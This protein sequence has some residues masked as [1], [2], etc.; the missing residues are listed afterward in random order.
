MFGNVLIILLLIIAN[1]VFSMSEIAVISSRKVRLQ[2]TA[3]DGDESSRVALDLAEKPNQFLSTIQ[4]GITLI[5]TLSGAL[6]SAVFSEPLAA[7]IAQVEVLKPYAGSLSVAIVVLSITYLSLVVGELVPKQLALADPERIA[8]AVARP[9]QFLSKLTYPIVRILSLST[10][11]VIRMMRL[12]ETNE[13]PVTE[14]EIRVLMEQGTEVGVF[15]KA[16]THM[17]E[18]VFRLGG[19][20]VGAVMTP[21]TDIEWLDLDDDLEISMAKV[22]ASPHQHFPLAEGSLDNVH[23]I[24]RAKDFLF[25]VQENNLDLLKM[26][27][28]ALFVPESTSALKLLELL[29]SAS[30]NLALVMD[31]YGGVL[32][33][34]TLF[35][36]MEAIVGVISIE[37]RP[38]QPLAT[39]RE[40]G[41]WLVDGTM[42]VDQFKD[43]LDRDE[44]PDEARIGF[45]TVAGFMLARI[46]DIPRPGQHFTWDAFRFEVMDMDGLRVDKVL[47]S[48]STD[49]S[50][51]TL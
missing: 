1:G 17:V 37:G 6:G 39:Q 16:E 13:P 45:Q 42:P 36:V 46:G 29:R 41:S 22:K 27:Q 11:L 8:R 26:A 10:E 23:G 34:V 24:V 51:D 30:G 7:R 49:A 19:R 18:G 20:L 21:R 25:G 50:D 44:L 38:A 5:G 15:D 32:G 9:M 33:L 2:Q 4:V 31:E 35:D 12:R 28:P 48:I 14:E 3:D 40:D 47:V 43:L